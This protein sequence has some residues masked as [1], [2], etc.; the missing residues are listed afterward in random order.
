MSAPVQRPRVQL[1]VRTAASGAR[2]SFRSMIFALSCLSLAA[3]PS[4]TETDV[5][6]G[7]ALPLAAGETIVLF[8]AFQDVVSPS[9]KGFARCVRAKIERHENASGKIMD[10][11]AFQ[12]ALFPWFEPAQAPRTL[13]ELNNLISRPE[14]RERIFSLKVRY[15]ISMAVS[16]ESDGFPGFV[17]GAGYGGAGCL[18]LGWENQ[19]FAMYAIV[20]DLKTGAEA[21]ELTASSAGKSLAIGAGIPIIFTAYTEEDACEALAAALGKV[22]EGPPDGESLD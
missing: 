9:A 10:T 7:S 15:L 4:T 1:S 20:W 5:S 17:C 18:G 3:C 8:P 11:A 6:V 14:I 13:D 12:D 21:G 16:T 2:R 22:L 19:D